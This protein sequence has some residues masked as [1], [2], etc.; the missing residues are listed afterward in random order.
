MNWI[1]REKS[2]KFKL[3]YKGTT[4]GDTIDI[5]HK[6]C[7]FPTISIIESTYDQIFGGYTT[8]SWDKNNIKD[9]DS[10]LFNLNIRKNIQFQIIGDY[11]E[12][13]YVFWRRKFS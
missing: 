8:K 3:L 5:F 12:V 4:D 11:W 2:F 9:P 1:N 13:I 6:K 7:Q 10:F